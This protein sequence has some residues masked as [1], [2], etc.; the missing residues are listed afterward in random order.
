MAD[1]TDLRVAPMSPTEIAAS[2]LDLAD[3]RIRVFAE[4]PYL[5]DG[6]LAYERQYLSAYVE[7]AEALMV[8]VRDGDRLV[9]VATG[10]P[11]EDHDDA[12]AEAFAG[13]DLP[14]GEIFYCGESVLLPAYRGRGIGHTFFEL[15][16]AHAQALGRRWSA[17]CAV[18]RPPGHPARPPG[19]RPLDGF[20]RSRGYAELPG[21]TARLRWRDLGEAEETEKSMQFWIRSLEGPAR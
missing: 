20:W 16:E 10:T 6:D 1:E 15:R 13:R 19:Y 3:L 8:G 4:Y 9:G 21:A 14:V 18:I 17:F 2:L 11:M 7:S 12:L 5:Y